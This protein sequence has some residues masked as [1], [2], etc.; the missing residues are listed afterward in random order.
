MS[1]TS[2]ISRVETELQ[3]YHR[4]GNTFSI[5]KPNVGSI[6]YQTSKQTGK[7]EIFVVVKVNKR[8]SKTNKGIISL[9]DMKPVK[10]IANDNIYYDNSANTITYRLNNFGEWWDTT[11]KNAYNFSWDNQ[12]T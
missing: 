3:D 2:S 4:E 6:L 7:V 12:S 1:S 10:N 9:I 8:K 5:V 11:M